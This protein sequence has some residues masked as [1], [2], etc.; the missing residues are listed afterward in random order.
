MG[1]QQI[2]PG[3]ERTEFEPAV[4]V[5]DDDNRRSADRRDDGVGNGLTVVVLDSAC[6]APAVDEVRTTDAAACEASV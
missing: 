4:L 5:R 1:T 3:S 6:N 2:R